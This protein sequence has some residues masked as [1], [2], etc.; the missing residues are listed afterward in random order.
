VKVRYG[1][2]AASSADDAITAAGNAAMTYMNVQVFDEMKLQIKIRNHF[3][4]FSR[5]LESRD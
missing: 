1:E 2:D 4:N 5:V 3:Q